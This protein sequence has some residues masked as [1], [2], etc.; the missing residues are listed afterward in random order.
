MGNEPAHFPENAIVAHLREI[1]R[2][3]AENGRPAGRS[4]SGGA[5]INVGVPTRV[6]SAA[7]QGEVIEPTPLS[8]EEVAHRDKLARELGILPPAEEDNEQYADLDS[9]LAAGESVKKPAQDAMAARRE[10]VTRMVDVNT[11]FGHPAPALAPTR[12]RL[13]DFRR[14]QSID[15]MR[16]VAIVDDFEIEM[17]ASDLRA[18]KKHVLELAVDHVTR[19]LALALSEVM[20][21][22]EEGVQEVP[23]G[24]VSGFVSQGQSVEGRTTESV[25]AVRSEAGDSVESGASAQSV[26]AGSA[27]TGDPAQ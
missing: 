9:A 5:P 14:I 3:N 2:I 27:P 11:M 10:S 6:S 19:Q 1:Q 17:P 24:T 26:D 20:D 23:S 4:Y 8:P 16:G 7:M 22:R 25:Q 15:L 21:G 13:I 12:A 18:I